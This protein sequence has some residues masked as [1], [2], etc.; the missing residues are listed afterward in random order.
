MDRLIE[1]DYEVHHQ[2]C[3]ANIMHIADSISRFLA[4][5][6]HSA[7]TIDLKRMVLTAAPL[8]F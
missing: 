2:S 3:K 5:Y 1:Y 4:K 8:Y 7:T 6:S